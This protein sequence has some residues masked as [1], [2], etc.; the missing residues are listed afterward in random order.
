MTLSA[1]YNSPE[2][3]RKILERIMDGQ[4]DGLIVEGVRTA[5]S[6]ANEACFRRL[7][8]RNVPVLFMNG[9][10]P[11]LK[12]DIPYVIMDDVEGGRM[13]ARTLIEKGYTRPAGFFKTDDMQGRERADGMLAELAEQGIEIPEERMLFF[14]TE[15]RMDIMSTPE[16]KA[17]LDMLEAGEADCVVCY[18]DSFALGLVERL[19]ARG[20]KLP[21]QLGIIS[22]DNSNYATMCRPQLTTL[23]HKKEEFGALVGRKMLRMIDGKKERSVK[24]P[25][26]LV[27]RESLPEKKA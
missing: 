6:A 24:V 25:W 22:F 17:F 18:N 23:N 27:E 9:Y 19:E 21:E 12:I 8:E 20:M 7:A 4:V 1:N 26:T 16:G 10:Y 15:H 11:D 5:R 14:G 3:E 2:A 13:A